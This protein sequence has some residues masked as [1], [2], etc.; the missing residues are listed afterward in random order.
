MIC[1]YYSLEECYHREKVFD[2]LDDLQSNDLIIYKLISNDI[3]EIRDIGLS[4]RQSKEVLYFFDQY[5]LLEYP[6]YDPYNEYDEDG[7]EDDQDSY[8]IYDDDY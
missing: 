6:D 7:D 2:Y 8:L 3:I 4:D 5:D 1:D